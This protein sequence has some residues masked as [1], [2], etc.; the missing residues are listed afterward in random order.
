MQRRTEPELP[1]SEGSR[2]RSRPQNRPRGLRAR[3]IRGVALLP[4]LGAL[5]GCGR[6]SGPAILQA[7]GEIEAT[8]VRVSTKVGGTLTSLRVKEGSSVRR[9]DLLASI[10]TTDAAL[11]L[12]AARA[13]EAYA[14]ADLRLRLS[15]SRV[16]DIRAAEAQ[17][18]RAK[19]DLEGA[20]QDLARME[21][22][23][24]EGSGT[25]K[26]RDDARTRRDVAKATRDGARE[27]WLRLKAG[28]RPEE[29]DVA[30]ARLDAA[31]ARATQLEQ[32]IRDARIFSPVDGV[33]TEKLVE[34]GELLAPGT[35]LLVITDMAHPWLTVY[36]GEPDLGRIRLGQSAVVL[37]DGGEQR[38]GH[39]SYIASESEFT[40]KNVQTRDERVKLVFRVRILLQNDDGL[41]KPGMPA[42]ARLTVGAGSS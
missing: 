17:L 30:R 18:A 38:I 25:T 40:P 15:G 41:F 32:Q 13:D 21:A 8:E 24:S 4:V 39:V 14:D 11:A 37:T 28:S 26:A 23:L 12:A 1:P 6:S 3:L 19:A 27:Q 2:P 33:V 29:I 9:G 35:P 20:E 16:E 10:D 31:K 5:S 22:L 42:R 7:S 36:L 34:E